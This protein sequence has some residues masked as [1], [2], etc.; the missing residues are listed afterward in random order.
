MFV[1]PHPDDIEIAVGSTVA[2]LAREGKDVY[3]L[4]CTDG[5]FGT[6]DE[7]VSPETLV[8]IRRDEQLASAKILGVKDVKFLPFEDGGMY[9]EVA[10]RIEIAKVIAEIKPDVVIGPDHKLYPESHPDHLRVGEAVSKAYFMCSNVNMMKKR[11]GQPKL[12]NQWFWRTISPVN[13]TDSSKSPKKTLKK[14]KRRTL[15]S[16][17]NVP[18]PTTAKVL[19]CI[20]A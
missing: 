11:Q 15:A 16:C 20:C 8:K 13:P 1:A 3:Y 17:H 12:Q 14:Q 5:R 19:C 9:D 2:R 6:E 18:R 4:V 10:L 7:K